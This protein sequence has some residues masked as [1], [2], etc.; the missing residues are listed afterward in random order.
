MLDGFGG[1][2]STMIAAFKARR[3]TRLMELDP[4]F[5]DVIV[6]RW[7]AFTGETAVLAGTAETFTAIEA[8]RRD[9]VRRAG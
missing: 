3:R 2:G 6:R 7:Q 9:N 8:A 5:C 1:S 4:K